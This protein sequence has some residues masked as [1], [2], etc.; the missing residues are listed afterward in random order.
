MKNL[1]KFIKI[2]ILSILII[3]TIIFTLFIIDATDYDP[4]YVNRSKLETS[5]IHIN[6]R[7]SIKFSNFLRNNYF[8]FYEKLF[9]TSFKERWGIESAS[10]RAKLP[11]KKIIKKIEKNFSKPIYKVDDYLINNNWTRSHGNYFSTRFSNLNE[12]NKNNAN[13]LKLAWVYEAKMDSG[14]SKENQ[15]NAVFYDNRIFIPDVDNKLV[16]LDGINGQKIW[17]LKIPGGIAL[18]VG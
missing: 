2:S 5:V 7:H 15:A 11:E 12:I 8:Y 16:S 17:E 9:N 18:N 6:S 13:N 1:F 4:H 3:F 10:S 14:N